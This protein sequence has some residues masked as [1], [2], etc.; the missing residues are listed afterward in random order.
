MMILGKNKETIDEETAHSIEEELRK[1]AVK[2]DEMV[3][4]QP[5]WANSLVRINARVDE[6]T[7]GKS[8]SLSWAVRVAIP[9]IV[10]IITFLIG[11]DYYIP[12][13]LPASP[14]MR[15]FFST[16]SPATIDS[17]TAIDDA[18]FLAA[19]ELPTARSFSEAQI[20]DY[21][22]SAEASEELVET[23]SEEDLNSLFSLL[24]SKN[25][26]IH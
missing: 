4:P 10:A 14:S 8:L 19:S 25:G 23:L 11:L 5:Y 3:P 18:A 15:S 6:A 22:I 12:D 26:D 24:Q 13:P 21:F 16:L 17:L 2:E 9:G 1:H 20:A 7:S